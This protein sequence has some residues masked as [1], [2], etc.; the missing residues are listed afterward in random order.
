MP[1]SRRRALWIDEETGGYAVDPSTDGSGYLAV[2]A[3]EL[4]DLTMGPELLETNYFT[5]RLHNTAPI[6]GADRAE[7]TFRIPLIGLA[8]AAGDGVTPGSDDWL[9]VILTHIFGRVTD[10][11]QTVHDGE[12]LAV[13]STTSSLVLDATVTGLDDNDLV[14]VYDSTLSATPRT[15][16]SRVSD[17]AS[18]PTYS[19]SPNFDTAPTTA[20]VAYGTKL[21]RQVLGGGRTIAAVYQDDTVGTYEL[22]GGRVTS[23]VI[24]GTAGQL[25]TAEVTMRFDSATENASGKSAL[26][27][28]ASPASTPIRMMTSPLWFNGSK[29]ASAAVTIDLGIEAAIIAATSGSQGRAD[30]ESIRLVP[31]VTV[32]PLR[33]DANRLLRNNVTTGELLVQLGSG[34]LASSQLNTMA[35]NLGSVHANEVSFLD[36][37]GVSRQEIQFMAI[38]DGATGFHAQLARA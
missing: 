10:G 6:A 32:Q 2:P 24:S 18:E 23:F 36:A 22:L 28:Q 27:A 35:F 19:V 7:L 25:A 9:D 37:E 15:Q 31:T 29:M 11:G 33:T 1:R 30:D 4:G 5:G 12:G 8:S 3:L 16:W 34:V 13:G 38:D 26:P 21:Y 20:G 17:D 14:A